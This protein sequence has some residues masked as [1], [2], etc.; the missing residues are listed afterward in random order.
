MII[1]FSGTGNSLYVAH[2][3]S[4]I[5]GDEV[6]QITHDCQLP[7]TNDSHVIWVFP[8]YSWGVPPV[9]LEHI[10]R[11]A[12]SGDHY[13]VVT[14]GD[15]TGNAHRQWR[16]LVSRNNGR[17]MSIYSV[18]MPNTYVMMKGF[19]VDTPEVAQAKIA[20]ASE[21]IAYIAKRIEGHVSGENDVVRGR[22]AWFKSAIIYPWFMRNAM[23]PK[24]FHANDKC[25]G[26]GLCAKNCPMGN[27][28]MTEGRPK[29]NI[30][31]AMC[32]RCYHICPYNSVAYGKNT[33]GK[34]QY[35]AMISLF[36]KD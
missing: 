12:F 11:Y 19:D 27:I 34:G 17:D 36:G 23:S 5:L 25:V 26:C 31:C 15:D 9:V 2:E 10:E 22:F 24:P 35:K 8:I 29:W 32:A 33:V 3:L 7:T 16:R 21:R 28:S 6:V 4:R 14:C 13:A 20:A 30:N 18:Q 1:V